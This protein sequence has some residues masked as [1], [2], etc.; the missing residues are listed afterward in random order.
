MTQRWSRPLSKRMGGLLLLFAFASAQA[1]AR[2]GTAP[3]PLSLGAR[4]DVDPHAEFMNFQEDWSKLTLDGSNLQPQPPVLGIKEDVPGKPFIRL[5][6]QLYW[7][8]GDP[9]DVYIILPRGVKKPP[10]ALYLYSYPEDK[11]RFNDD[12]WC[13]AIG[14]RSTAAVGF[15]SAWTGH[16]TE[17]RSP[18][19]WFVSELQ[20]SLAT[21]VHDVQMILNYLASRGDLDMD[22]VAMFGQGSGATIAILASAADPRIK[23][24]DALAPWGDWP[25]WI[26][27]TSMVPDNER[28]KYSNPEFLAKVAK[29]DPVAWLPKIKAKSFRL[30]DVRHDT[31]VPD[32]AEEKMEAAAP[33]FA[34]INQYGDR[35]ALYP[36]VA[37]GKIFLWLQQQVEASGTPTA[38][39]NK[40]ERI[41]FFPAKGKDK[42]ADTPLPMPPANS[43]GRS[44]T[45]TTPART[46]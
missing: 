16:R 34:E 31:A 30:Q 20:E 1:R 25:D 22:R 6:Y 4:R 5:L 28:A 11:N 36:E 10:V 45:N 9:L 43:D 37:G 44:T 35:V 38:A 17:Y 42:T 33:D 27:K 13:S 40:G 12:T 2:Q 19:K 24:V 18:Q 7:R 14:G 23:A 46:P 26:A 8:P 32:V 39:L 15:V 41:H 29:L 21:S 3:N